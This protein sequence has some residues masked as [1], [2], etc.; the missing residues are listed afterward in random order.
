[1]L[2]IKPPPFPSV[3]E[4]MEA[5]VKIKLNSSV[6][7]K[8]PFWRSIFSYYSP[9]LEAYFCPISSHQQLTLERHWCLCAEVSVSSWHRT[10]VFQVSYV[11]H[12]SDPLYRLSHFSWNT[13]WWL[14][15]K[16]KLMREQ[17]L[18]KGFFFFFF[19]LSQTSIWKQLQKPWEQT[20]LYFSIAHRLV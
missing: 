2:F 9:M 3:P 4:I 13:L 17:F 18:G 1:M 15:F 5:Y 14:Q 19:N 20:G 8:G 11:S 12:V 7:S 10:L 16:P 6:A